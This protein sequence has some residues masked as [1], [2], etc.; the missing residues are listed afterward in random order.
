ML[1][2]ETRFLLGGSGHNA[3][4]INPPSAN[5]HGYWTNVRM[6]A[7]AEGWLETATRHEGSWWPAWQQWLVE[8]GRGVQVKARKPRRA[9]EP[10]PGSYVRG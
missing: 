3:G 2:G 8:G 10:A 6:P 9:I 1:G 4:V 5:R 7:T